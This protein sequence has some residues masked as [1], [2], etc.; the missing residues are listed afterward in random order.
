MTVKAESSKG[1]I[2]RSHLPASAG[3]IAAVLLLT[4]ALLAHLIGVFERSVWGDEAITLLELSGHADPTFPTTPVPIAELKR[5]IADSASPGVL[6]RALWATDVHPPRSAEHT[7][8]LQSLM[9]ISYA[10]FC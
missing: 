3:S 7:S 6:V 5:Q 2:K 4:V 10:V 1:A 9:R 8:E